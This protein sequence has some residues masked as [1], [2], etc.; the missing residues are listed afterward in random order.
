MVGFEYLDE[1]ALLQML[2][3]IVV[4]RLSEEKS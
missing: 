3:P 2:A 4:D 1:S